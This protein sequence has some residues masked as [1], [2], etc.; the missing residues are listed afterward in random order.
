MPEPTCTMINCY[1]H[2]LA[3]N[4]QELEPEPACTVTS[5]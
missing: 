2:S 3:L 4:E 1:A 5:C